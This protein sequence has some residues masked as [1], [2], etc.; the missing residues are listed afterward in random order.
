[1][2]ET[3]M[4]IRD[5]NG[6]TEREFLQ[7]YRADKY[8]RPSMTADIVLL[9]PAGEG[10][11]ALLIRRGGHPFLGCWALPGGFV[12]PQESVDAAAA[13][14]LTEETHV[15]GLPLRPLVLSSAPGRDPRTWTISMAYLAVADRGSLPVRADDDAAEARWFRLSRTGT[16]P[17]IRL[18]LTCDDIRLTAALRAGLA[19]APCGRL[20]DIR[21]ENAGGIAF[22]HAAILLRALFEWEALQPQGGAAG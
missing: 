19:D 13:R 2:G 14:E 17:D 5:R 9:S 20:Y 10:V 15:T 7:R 11:E 6:L 8:P 3:G 18:S 21:V 1:M 22:D 12:G 16:L 4:E